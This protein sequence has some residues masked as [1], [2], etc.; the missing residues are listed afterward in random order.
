MKYDVIIVG[1]GPA[2]S[3][4]ALE[5]GL[6]GRHVLL[7]DGSK[8]PREKVCGEG[9]MPQGVQILQERGFVSDSL[10]A[11]YR[12]FGI[13]YTVPGGPKASAYF[14]SSDILPN[15]G[16]AMRRVSLDQALLEQCKK[17]PGIELRLGVFVEALSW[18]DKGIPRVSGGGVEAS[19]DFVVGADG[20]GS[21][22]RRLANL[23]GV[24]PGKTRW[25]VRGH[26]SHAP[27]SI[28][29]PQVEVI[30]VNDRE[31]YLTPLSSTS[32]G[33]IMTLGQDQLKGIQGRITA[34]LLETL[35]LSGDGFCMELSRSE[36]ISR[37]QAT[38]PLGVPAK[39]SFGPR[40]LL[41]GDAAGALD[42]ITGEGLSISLKSSVL[43]AQTIHGAFEESDFGL[44]RL[45]SYHKTRLKSIR[46]LS[47]LTSLVLWLSQHPQLAHRIIGNL[48]QQPATFSKLLGIAAGTYGIRSLSPRDACRIVL[49][50]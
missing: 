22:V 19:G 26:F 14:P 29:R 25:A 36:L 35:K 38:G 49:G 17:L 46:E 37:V 7:L 33:V 27:R 48:G 41:V 45:R 40:L 6:A 15:Y 11:G 32:T 47:M 10:E 28:E 42:P 39:S 43:A 9:M 44:K 13:R 3:L 30:M 23:E 50:I 24:A 4:L 34:A 31:M 18:S 12:F 16:V 21:V 2:G 1:A 20:S 8:F 5:L